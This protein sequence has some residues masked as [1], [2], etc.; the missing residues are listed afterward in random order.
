M[1]LKIL[2]LLE[3][4]LLLDMYLV[5]VVLSWVENRYYELENK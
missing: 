5:D 4:L 1:R 3:K 2:Y